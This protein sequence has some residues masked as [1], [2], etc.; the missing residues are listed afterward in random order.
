MNT[1]AVTCVISNI[2][3]QVIPLNG[4]KRNQKPNNHLQPELAELISQLLAA[5]TFSA[6]AQAVFAPFQF[7]SGHSKLRNQLGSKKSCNA[8]FFF[9][10]SDLKV[11]GR[12]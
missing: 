5:M 1:Q 2:L 3:D 7:S 9:P 4:K 11:G 10:T 8:H 6:D 12:G